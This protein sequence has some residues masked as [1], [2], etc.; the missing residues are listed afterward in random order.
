MCIYERIIKSLYLNYFQIMG[1]IYNYRV[2]FVN[3]K[4][5]HNIICYLK[6]NPITEIRELQKMTNIYQYSCLWVYSI[7]Y[8]AW[9]KTC[10]R[11]GGGI[12]IPYFIWLKKVS[13]SPKWSYYLLFFRG[14]AWQRADEN[15]IHITLDN[16]LCSHRS[17]LGHL[18]IRGC[19]EMWNWGIVGIKWGQAI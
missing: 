17:L 11:G 3:V 15:H 13:K 14:S 2:C 7:F 10:R 4:G 18:G 5:N 16:A 1:E 9:I 8:N 6:S 19:S 12:K